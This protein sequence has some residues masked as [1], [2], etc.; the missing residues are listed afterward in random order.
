M[1]RIL[2]VHNSTEKGDHYKRVLTKKYPYFLTAK[3]VDG[4]PLY[5]VH[6]LT[7]G[8]GGTHNPDEPYDA[9]YFDKE[10]VRPKEVLKYL[11][12]YPKATIHWISL[13]DIVEN[14]KAKKNSTY[15]TNLI[16]NFD[17][18]KENNGD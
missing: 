14:K 5:D 3:D 17:E 4:K 7:L 9:I 8:V 15:I 6:V 11:T 18:F 1:I 13:K 10:T 2:F 16:K 12:K